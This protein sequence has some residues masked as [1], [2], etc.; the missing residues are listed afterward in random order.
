MTL[1]PTEEWFLKHYEDAKK[2]MINIFK[3][4][5]NKQ[6]DTI[7]PTPTSPQTKKANK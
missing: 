7:Y 3:S 1:S 6:I 2:T 5:D 4:P